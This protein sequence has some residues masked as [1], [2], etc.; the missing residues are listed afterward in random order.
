MNEHLITSIALALTAVLGGLAWWYAARAY[1]RWRLARRFR[2][3]A[4]GEQKARAGLR[5]RG[6]AIVE[7]QARRTP[8]MWI[9][10]RET[11]FEVRADFVVRRKGRRAVVEVKTGARAVDPTYRPTRR[12]LLEYGRCFDTDDV[13]LY[14][15][16]SDELLDVRFGGA[17]L[18]PG[19]RLRGFGAGFA[20]GVACCAAAALLLL[21]RGGW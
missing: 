5:K 13:Y 3:G 8:V 17:A 19:A 18:A 11:P 20:A 6:F 4:R 2:H 10:G 7:E 21:T 9:G 1:R 12:Q 15:A 16:D 14:D